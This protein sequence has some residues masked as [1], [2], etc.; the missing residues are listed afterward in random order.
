MEHTFN[1]KAKLLT[2]MNTNVKNLH[3]GSCHAAKLLLKN[4]EHVP[5]GGGESLGIQ[6]SN[7]AA[8]LGNESTK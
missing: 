7:G 4:G 6:Q 3:I 1:T 5:H 8:T 2:V